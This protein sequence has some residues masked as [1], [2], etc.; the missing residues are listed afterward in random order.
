M[1]TV[2]NAIRA[3]TFPFRAEKEEYAL[4]LGRFHP[5]KAPHLAIDAAGVLAATWDESGSGSRLLASAIGRSDG[6]GRVRFTRS[7]G[8]GDVG[9]YPYLVPVQG[10]WLRAWTSGAP[11]RSQIRLAALP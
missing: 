11:D 7:S 1:A 8:A 10:A 5:E 4:F 2:H 9:T 6:S 3:E